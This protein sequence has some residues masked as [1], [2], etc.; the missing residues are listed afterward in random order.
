MHSSGRAP[1]A[2]TPEQINRL[3][4]HRLEDDL[5][6]FGDQPDTVWR[7]RKDSPGGTS[8]RGVAAVEGDSGVST[9]EFHYRSGLCQPE[10][11]VRGQVHVG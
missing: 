1:P 11:Q 6:M 7:I 9:Y 10:A 2:E 5:W 3:W 4:V 8:V